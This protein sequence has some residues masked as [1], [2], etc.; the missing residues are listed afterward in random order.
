MADLSLVTTNFFPTASETFTDNLSGSISA[1]AGTVP[2]NSAVEYANGAVVVLTVEPG[3]ANEATFIGVKDTT[4]QFINCIWTEG[5][6]GV[7][8]ANGVTIIDYDS[9]THFDALSKGVQQTHNQN[10]TLKSQPV[11]DALGLVASA[12]NG[13]EVFPYTIS[14]ASGYNNGHRNFSA[15]VANQDVRSFISKDMKFKAVRGTTAPTQ[16]V[17]LESTSSQYANRVSASVTG[18]LS[19]MTDDIT[20]EAWVKPESFT[21]VNPIIGRFDGTEANGWGMKLD[22]AGRPYIIGLNAGASNYRQYI[23]Y[24]GV[25]IGIWTHLAS[26]MDMSGNSGVIYFNGVSVTVQTNLSG[27]NPTAFVNTGNL[28]IGTNGTA[29]TQFFD[30]KISDVRVW[31][32]VRTGLQI[33]DNMHQ[34]LVGSE[35]NLVGYWKLNGNFTDS[36][37]SVNTLTG[38][39]GAVATNVDNP[40]AD[41]FM[42]VMDV[43]F[44]SPNSTIVFQCPSGYEIPNMSLTSP[45]YSSQGKPYGWISDKQKWQVGV[46]SYSDISTGCAVASTIYPTNLNLTL[47]LGAWEGSFESCNETQFSVAA[48]MAY[49]VGVGLATNSLITTFNNASTGISSNATWHAQ[50][51]TGKDLVNNA[52]ATTYYY[53]VMAEVVSGTTTMIQ[54]GPRERTE[55]VFIP[56][57][58]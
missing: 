52:A 15:T 11:R 50:K 37:A 38:S 40:M 22:A 20:T 5:N 58:L 36:N 18:T 9:A 44:S 17:D 54:H 43:T 39:G 35:T 8:H 10:G 29:V 30:G 16:C 13:W 34:Q 49:R 55:L 3:T 47:P 6:T 7:G 19:T 28:A 57:G 2:V 1:G 12:A 46:F 23:A 4:N 14:V 24:Q 31:N 21:T 56:Q 27:T 25:D 53:N 33:R 42:L 32:A 48:Q 45:Y 51:M 26:S 41:P